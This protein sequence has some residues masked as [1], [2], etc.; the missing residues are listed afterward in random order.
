MTQDSPARTGTEVRV[1]MV[2]EAPIAQAYQVFTTGI[3]S[4]WNRDHHI[5]PSPLAEEVVE[6]F[7]GGRLYGR[8]V[9][10]TECAWGRV[11]VWQPPTAFS[12]T[13]AIDLTWQLETDPARASRVDVTFTPLDDTRTSVTLI[14]SGFENH[15][16]GWESMRDAV[17][18]PGGWPA[19]QE[20]YVK[21]VATA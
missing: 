21:V 8:C 9:D 17:A 18:S 11:L 7:E 20:E 14:H 10:G 3:D 12:F 16:D 1:D 15:G 19:L 6:P 5:G 4:W 13:W 2:V